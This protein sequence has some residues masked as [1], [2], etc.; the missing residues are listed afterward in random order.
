M[1][2]DGDVDGG[3]A[4]TSTPVCCAFSVCGAFVYVVGWES[5]AS[6]LDA[7][8]GTRTEVDMNVSPC[9]ACAVSSGQR[10]W[11]VLGLEPGLDEVVQK[12]S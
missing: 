8:A 11:R 9:V 1:G 12:L 7:G 2:S 6:E 3:H 4:R 10:K 5:D